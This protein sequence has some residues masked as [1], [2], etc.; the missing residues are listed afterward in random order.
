[1]GTVVPARLRAYLAGRLPE[2]MVPSAVVGVAALPMTPSGKLDRRALPRPG[3]TPTGAGRPPRGPREE[4]LCRLFADVL[5]LPSV[6]VDDNFFDLGGHSLVAIR[7]ISR[8]HRELGTR[9]SIRGVFEAPTPAT[10]AERLNS[11]TDQDALA[12]LLPLRATG[13]RPPL[14]CVHP[15]AG[16][17]WVYSGLLRHLAPDRPVYGLQARGLGQPGERP[18]S[19]EEMVKDYLGQI[20]TVQPHGPYHLLGWSFGAGVAYGVATALQADGEHVELLALL[21][22]YPSTAGGQPALAADDP[23]VLAA[24]LAS[25]GY[26]STDPPRDHAGLEALLR[27]TDGPLAA[28]PPGSASALATVFADNINLMR[29]W[30]PGHYRGDVLFFTATADKTTGSPV[31]ADWRPYVSGVLDVHE[32]DCHHGAMTRPAP[33]A[34]IGAVLAARLP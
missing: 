14:F 18:S 21:D 6:G 7:L 22:G 17:S 2:F 19:V 24:L 12:V 32:V 27:G 33:I 29:R 28:L 4:M 8:I 11:F 10:M 16:V 20:R 1:V 30:T 34:E 13:D 15:A 3:L 23:V 9:V 25:L 26:P 5:N 31:P